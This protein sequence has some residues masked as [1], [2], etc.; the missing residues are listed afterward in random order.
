MPAR[1]DPQPLRFGLMGGFG[2]ELIKIRHVTLPEG[3]I[4]PLFADETL[5]IPIAAQ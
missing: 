1:L 3:G 4:A 2:K 5:A